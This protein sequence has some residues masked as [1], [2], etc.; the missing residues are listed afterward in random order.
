MSTKQLLEHVRNIVNGR[1]NGNW[2]PATINNA[3]EKISLFSDS[4]IAD[5]ELVF[6][7][8]RGWIRN[9]IGHILLKDALANLE[10]S[11]YYSKRALRI[12][13]HVEIGAG[14]PFGNDHIL[15]KL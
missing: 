5:L 14:Y 11:L 3:C 10:K 12:K 1:E 7:E 13:A 2:L 15:I 9:E 4:E 8:L 6:F